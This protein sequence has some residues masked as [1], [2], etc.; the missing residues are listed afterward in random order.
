V[1]L[2]W[3]NIAVIAGAIVFVAFLVWRMRPVTHTRGIRRAA[4]AALA[5]RERARAARTPEQRARALC[6][7]GDAFAAERGGSLAAVGHYL[8][9]ARLA[10]AWPEPV[11]RLRALLWSRHPGLLERILWR[12]LAG[13][14]WSGQTRPVAALAASTLAELY[15]SRIRSRSKA[16]ALERLAA[17]LAEPGVSPA[18]ASTPDLPS[19]GSA[20][21]HSRS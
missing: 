10:P 18:P 6:D 3:Q 13:S 15:R 17:L 8:R 1:T 12:Q 9:A 14:T 2:D 4:G 11:A 7:A 21:P 16:A 19:A 5:A 20:P